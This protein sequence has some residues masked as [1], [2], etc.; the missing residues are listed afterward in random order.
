MP[1]TAAN[2]VELLRDDGSRRAHLVAHAIHLGDLPGSE[3]RD[4]E[5]PHL[6]FCHQLGDGPEGVLGRR[7]AVGLVQ[8]EEVDVVGA[9]PAQAGLESEPQPLRRQGR[10][11]VG[12]TEEHA[13]LGGEGDLVASTGKQLREDAFGLAARVSVG[14]VDVGDAGIECRVEQSARPVEV[15]SVAEGHG[16]QHHRAERQG[17]EH[18]AG[19]P[20]VGAGR[21]DRT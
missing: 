5:R 3:I 19:T 12:V 10:V 4:A 6:A 13:A 14:G 17:A 2:G 15:D 7:R 20:E 21:P 8:V 9:E 1:L 11:A 18:H 16:A